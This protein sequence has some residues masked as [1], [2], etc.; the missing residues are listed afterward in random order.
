MFYFKVLH[1]KNIF[2]PPNSLISVF[3]PCIACNHCLAPIL[4]IENILIAQSFAHLCLTAPY[5]HFCE[6]VRHLLWE[7]LSEHP[8][9]LCCLIIEYSCI[10]IRLC[11]QRYRDPSKNSR[12]QRTQWI[13]NIH[14][15]FWGQHINQHSGFTTHTQRVFVIINIT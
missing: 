3:I 4:P 1:C 8:S 10:M 7:L 6:I 5:L 14:L 15:H 9:E 12:P 11:P 2:H 13:Y